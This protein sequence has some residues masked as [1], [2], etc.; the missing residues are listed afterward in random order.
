TTAYTY[1]GNGNVL[2]KTEPNGAAYTTIYTY[3]EL[4]KLLSVD[5]TRGGAGGVTLY[6]YDANRNRIAQQDASGNLTIYKYDALN[7]LSDTSQS[8][9]PGSL[10][11]GTTRGALSGPPS[12]ALHW[13]Y[14]YDA[15]DNQN[16]VIDAKGQRTDVN[17]DYLNRLA[18]VTY[19]QYAD[20]TLD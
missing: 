13:Q 4:N 1:D 20:P 7:R 18:T 15:N 16:L 17:Y 6:V 11:A 12:P 14:G 2:T 10:P 9:T 8:L 19:S 3:D 5:E